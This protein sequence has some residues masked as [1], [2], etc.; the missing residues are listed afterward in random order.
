MLTISTE[1]YHHCGT[2]NKD[3]YFTKK[4]RLRVNNGG[5]IIICEDCLSLLQEEIKKVL[6]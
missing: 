3:N 1:E 2:C 6:K 5:Y 4:Y